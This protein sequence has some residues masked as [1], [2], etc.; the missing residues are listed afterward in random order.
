MRPLIIGGGTD[1][2]TLLLLKG[3]D[4]VDSS[5]HERTV[6]NTGGLIA[7]AVPVPSGN[8]GEYYDLTGVTTGTAKHIAVANDETLQSLTA[9]SLTIEFW[10][11]RGVLTAQTQFVTKGAAL[12][13]SVNPST[14]PFPNAN[15][16]FFTRRNGG[17]PT[18]LSS[19][20]IADTDWHHYAVTRAGDVWSVYV[21]GAMIDQDTMTTVDENTDDWQIGRWTSG[22]SVFGMNG[23]L[24]DFRMS[25]IAR[26][27]GDFTPP[28]PH[29]R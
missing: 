23:S 14:A 8:F 21:D 22:P 15:R 20:Q 26:Y 27:S 19:A 11:A 13:W 1:P 24:D 17:S 25:R 9:G 4:F 16:M 2:N 7:S 6:T 5:K 10:A 28:G 3:N 12:L 29:K 18:S